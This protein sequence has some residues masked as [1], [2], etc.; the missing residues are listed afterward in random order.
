MRQLLG[1]TAALGLALTGA[2]CITPS[3]PIPPPDPSNM[4]F[5]L[6]MDGPSSSATMTYPANSLYLGGVAY[7]YDQTTGHGAIADVNPDGSVGPITIPPPVNLGDQVVF[8]VQNGDQSGSS[9]VVLREGPQDPT[10]YC[11][12]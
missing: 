6:T 1:I 8:T 5:H 2:G 7:L 10:V 9:C 4:L 12:P 11:G 3:I